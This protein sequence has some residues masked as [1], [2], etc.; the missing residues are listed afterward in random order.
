MI[1]T[2]AQMTESAAMTTVKTMTIGASIMT[3]VTTASK[4]LCRIARGRRSKSKNKQSRSKT[5][6]TKDLELINQTSDA[7]AVIFNYKL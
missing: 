6:I 3:L 5:R 2:T 7:S 4:K 1:A